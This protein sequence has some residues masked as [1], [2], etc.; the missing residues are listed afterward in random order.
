MKLGTFVGQQ[1]VTVT[2][3]EMKYVNDEIQKVFG[4]VPSVEFRKTD[5]ESSASQ[6]TFKIY[7]NTSDN[8]YR[9]KSR[10]LVN[11]CYVKISLFSRYGY[12]EAVYGKSHTWNEG[13]VPPYDIHSYFITFDIIGNIRKKHCKNTSN[14]VGITHTIYNY[15]TELDDLNIDDILRITLNTITRWEVDNK[16]NVEF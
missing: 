12:D 16:T 14:M 5:I 11:P 9:T 6:T 1:S 10:D 4:Q 2:P 8:N 3:E 13:F 15:G 7:T